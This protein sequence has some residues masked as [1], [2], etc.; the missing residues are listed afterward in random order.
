MLDTPFLYKN[1][2]LRTVR[3]KLGKKIR[4]AKN[5]FK[6]KFTKMLRTTPRF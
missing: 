6:L 2:F 1:K 5:N 3:L 4:T